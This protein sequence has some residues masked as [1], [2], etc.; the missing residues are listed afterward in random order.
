MAEP[1]G[2]RGIDELAALVGHYCWLEGRLFELTGLWATAPAR[3]G[4]EPDAAADELRVWCAASSRR[5]GEL[6]ARWARR[7]PVRAGVDAGALVAAPSA[8]LAE[9][10][11]ALEAGVEPGDGV[12]VLVG[13]VLPWVD[14]LYRRHAALALAVSEGPVQEVLAEARRALGGE[15]RGGRSLLGRGGAEPF[16]TSRTIVTVLSQAL[17]EICVLPAVHP[18]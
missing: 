1:A 5:H 8:A 11:V 12:A 2:W 7:L 3:D 13:T 4:S 10:L 18:S 17:E 16:V 14:E 9:A 15:I 6:A